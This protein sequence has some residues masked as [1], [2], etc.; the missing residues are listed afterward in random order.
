LTVA[1]ARRWC[2]ARRDAVVSWMTDRGYGNAVMPWTA[3]SSFNSLGTLALLLFVHITASALS[4]FRCYPQNT[5]YA[6]GADAG[7]SLLG[8]PAIFCEDDEYYVLLA[9]NLVN[10][11]L[12]CLP[13]VSICTWASYVA[14]EKA[15]DAEANGNFFATFIFLFYRFRSSY[16]YWGLVVLLRNL[17]VALAPIISGDA[18]VDVDQAGI[19]AGLFVAGT[20]LLYAFGVAVHNP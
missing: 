1:T 3:Q 20:L 12:F 19:L 13:F 15:F 5:P 17:L 4:I 9:L 6:G 14:F 11:L 2:P 10:L 16:W 18:F 8:E 7:S